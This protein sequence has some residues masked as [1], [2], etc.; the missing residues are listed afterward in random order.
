MYTKTYLQQSTISNDAKDV[1]IYWMAVET[2]I[3]AN[4]RNIPKVLL[5]Y[6][7]TEFRLKINTEEIIQTFFLNKY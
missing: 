1:I 3:S 7:I 6:Q 2:V 5:K 4:Y